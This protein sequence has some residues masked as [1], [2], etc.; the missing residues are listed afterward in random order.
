MTAQQAPNQPFACTFTPNVP[1]LLK[2]LNCSL[3]IS[4]YQAGKLIFISPKD[5]EFLV[6]LPRTFDKPM[7]I[8]LDVDK[9]KLGLACKSSIEIFQNSKELAAYYP[10]SPNKYDALFMPRVS[11]NSG[12]IDIHD[13]SFGK[14]NRIFGVNTLFSCLVEFDEQYNFTPVWKP[15]FVS[16]LSA[17]DRCHLNGMVLENGLP[18]YATSF[19][20]GD[21]AQSWRENIT[22][23]GT[24]IDVT[25]DN[26]IADNLA[27]P[28][29]PILINGKLYVLLSATGQLIEVEVSTGKTTE[30]INLNGFVRGLS[31]HQE[32]LFIG[33]SKLR[34]NSSTF[35]KLD[36][37]DKANYAGIA[38]VH[39]PTGSFCGEIKY[40]NSVDEIYDIEVVPDLLRPN[41]VNSI[42]PESKMGISIP[43]QS[44]WA[45]N[46]KANEKS[47]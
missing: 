1:E 5:E 37:A 33:L 9:G 42:M 3:A 26:I 11:Y 16:K 10:K 15:K 43:N 18:K 24:L 14:A 34:K 36:I 2:K 40:H 4:T 28:H 6:Q 41:I 12:G 8:A 30:I 23:T 21:S 22:T 45:N 13:L 44:F 35:A 31:Y 25:T 32:Y 17:E 29:S 7:G 46:T 47:N 39:L 27:M 38:I 20:Q 19:N